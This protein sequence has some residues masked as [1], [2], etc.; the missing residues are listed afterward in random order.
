MSKM[1]I[2]DFAL[3]ELYAQ[4]LHFKFTAVSAG[5]T[6]ESP[7]IFGRKTPCR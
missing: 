2:N 4:K 5:S 6:T 3:G 1:L 7:R